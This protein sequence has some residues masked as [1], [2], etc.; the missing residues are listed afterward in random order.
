[1]LM[2]KALDMHIL[3]CKGLKKFPR[4]ETTRE[5]WHTFKNMLVPGTREMWKAMGYLNLFLPNN[6]WITPADY[7][8]WF[9]P[10]MDLWKYTPGRYNMNTYFVSI[11]EGLACSHP[12]IDWSPHLPFLFEVCHA[13]VVP[14]N[15]PKDERSSPLNRAEEIILT[16]AGKQSHSFG[17]LFAFVLDSQADSLSWKLL[18]KLIASTKIYMQENLLLSA[19]NRTSA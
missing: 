8:L 7:S 10:L 14:T 12:E 4:P 5:V 19:G 2:L 3:F 17:R 13:G 1:M 16:H 11:F 9:D 18:R 15:K 6:R